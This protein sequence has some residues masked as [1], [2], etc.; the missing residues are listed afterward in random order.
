MMVTAPYIAGNDRHQR[1]EWLG[2][3]FVEVLLDSAVTNG[4]LMVLRSE[5]RR[6]DASPLHVHGR[7]DET[8]LMLAGAAVVHVGDERKE[9]EEGGVAFLPRDIPHAYRITSGT[10]T[11]LTLTTPGGLEG[12]FRAAGHDI[13]APKP[14]G[15]EISPAT[16]AKA[17]AAHGG[18]ILGPPPGV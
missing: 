7:E 8:F 11:M 3:S 12:F 1:L 17:L 16:L 14:E 15:W 13:A 18:Q 4:Q 2:N 6:G 9:V 5:L 10:A